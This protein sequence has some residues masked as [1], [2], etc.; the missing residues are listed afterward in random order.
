[1]MGASLRGRRSFG[2]ILCVNSAASGIV[3]ADSGYR[4]RTG[5]PADLD[6]LN[7]IGNLEAHIRESIM[8]TGHDLPPDDLV[9]GGAASDR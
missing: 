2:E 7:G 5:Y 1:M 6:G 3:L 9:V 4:P 8:D